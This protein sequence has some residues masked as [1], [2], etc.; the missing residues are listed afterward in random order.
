MNKYYKF[1][2]RKNIKSKFIKKVI[3]KN[4]ICN[5]KNENQNEKIF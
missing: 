5:F 1:E 3:M 4:L 2:K